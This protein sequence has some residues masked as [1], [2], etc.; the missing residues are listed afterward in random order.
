MKKGENLW[1][2]GSLYRQ[3][4][5]FSGTALHLVLQGPAAGTLADHLCHSHSQDG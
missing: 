3:W 2:T 1:Q 5:S 4:H